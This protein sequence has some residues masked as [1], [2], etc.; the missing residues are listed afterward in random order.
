MAWQVKSLLH[1]PGDLSSIPQVHMRIDK[2]TKPTEATSGI[3]MRVVADT[4]TSH[5]FKCSI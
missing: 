2:E 5:T 4:K 1:K 3:P